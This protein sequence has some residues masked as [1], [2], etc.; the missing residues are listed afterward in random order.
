M[1]Y[2]AL[3]FLIITVVAAAFGFRE[4][5]TTASRISKGLFYLFLVIFVLLLI[6]NIMQGGPAPVP[7]A[8]EYS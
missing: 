5:S 6:L 3:I 2:W 1:L 8:N 7:P 4:K